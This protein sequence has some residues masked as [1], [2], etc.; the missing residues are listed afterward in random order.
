MTNETANCLVCEQPT[1][2]CRGLYEICPVCGWEDDDGGPYGPNGG[3]SLKQARAG[4][5]ATGD[6]FALR[7]LEKLE[8]ALGEWLDTVK[9]EDIPAAWKDACI[10]RVALEHGDG[11]VAR[12]ALQTAGLL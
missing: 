11:R 2:T 1:L 5:E 3:I 10:A 7:H 8:K 4:Y 12:H 9:A 6:S